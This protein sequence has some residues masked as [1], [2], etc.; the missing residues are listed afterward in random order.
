MTREFQT[1]LKRRL[2]RAGLRIPPDVCEKL[3]AYYR[4]LTR[5][6]Q[7]I[8]LTSMALEAFPD[9]T[10]DR[11]LVEPL[12]AARHVAETAFVIDVGSGGGSPAIPMKLALPGA[13][14]TMV[15]S[16]ARKAAFLREAIRQLDLHRTVAETARFE[17][18]LPRPD[19][20]EAADVLTMRAVRV[21]PKLLTTLQAFVKP[22][23]A[24]FLFR[25]PTGPDLPTE[26]T[27]PLAW[28]ATF[29]LVESLR[30]RLVVIRKGGVGPS[31]TTRP[32]TN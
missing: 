23:G 7:K 9:A 5:W 13:A 11:L 30:S 31:A 17:E 28:Q 32:P 10:L 24:L 29:P 14:M 3:E 8:N 26:L 15:E 25:G 18:L 21:E 19:L 22:A 2:V 1:R 4:L 16:K 6:N 27:P 12:V 20:H